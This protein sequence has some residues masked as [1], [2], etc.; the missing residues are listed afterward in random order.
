MG[1]PPVIIHFCRIFPYQPSSYWGTPHGYGNPQ[2][3]VLHRLRSAPGG[4]QRRHTGA[5]GRRRSAWM[6]WIVDGVVTPRYGKFM[7]NSLQS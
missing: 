3:M 2:N 4:G 6:V 7:G 1:V 5:P